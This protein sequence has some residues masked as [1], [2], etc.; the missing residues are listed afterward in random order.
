M[1]LEHY[2]I[3]EKEPIIAISSI[4]QIIDNLLRDNYHKSDEKIHERILGLNTA[5]QMIAFCMRYRRQEY[6][7][8]IDKNYNDNFS[9]S[10]EI[11][12]KLW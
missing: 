6:Y 12:E 3:E 8:Q 1:E 10:T 4:S 11:H 2:L 5:I 7:K 9:Y